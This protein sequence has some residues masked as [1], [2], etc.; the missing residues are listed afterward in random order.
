MRSMSKSRLKT[1]LLRVFRELE[2]SGEEL[3]VTDHNRPV[4]RIIPYR[5]RKAVGEAFA[6]I[7][8][9]LKFHEDPNQPTSEEWEDI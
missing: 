6:D 4:L 8:G 7:Q 1:H 9:E 5:K 2:E 3:I